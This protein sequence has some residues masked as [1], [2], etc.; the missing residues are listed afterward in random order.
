[1]KDPL[2]NIAVR[3]ARTAGNIIIR[4]LDRLDTVH[5]SEKSPYDYVTDIDQQAEREIIAVIRKAHPSHGI[6]GEEGGESPGDEFTWIIDP[7]DGTRNFIHG[8]PHFCV[9]IAISRRGRI[10]HG[11]I[12]DPVRQDLF[13]ASRGKGAQ[14]NDRRMRV[15]KRSD[16]NE[17]LLATGS[18]H[19]SDESEATAYMNSLISV[20]ETCKDVRRAGSAALDLAYVAAG[21][22]D[23]FWEMGLKQWDI[24]A[25]S[26]MIQEAGGLVSDFRG[27]ENYL[28][29]GNIVAGNPKVLK[30]LLQSIGPHLSNIG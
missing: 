28:K 19:T 13:T 16:P 8:V 27:S 24:A 23:G 11:V 10:E 17:C 25:G 1:M 18:P 21:R 6:I 12:Y 3:A 20:L 4:A 7:L 14:V 26:L 2:V 30:L 5:I 15:S 22:Y 29:T 9:S